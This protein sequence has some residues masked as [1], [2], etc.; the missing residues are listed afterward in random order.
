[1]EKLSAMLYKA[2]QKKNCLFKHATYHNCAK[3]GQIK[4]VCQSNAKIEKAHA[5]K[6]AE[7]VLD[8]VASSPEVS[9]KRLHS[10]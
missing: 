5:L 2:R 3:Q 1:M 10:Y 7:S 4:P 8:G 6:N 9:I